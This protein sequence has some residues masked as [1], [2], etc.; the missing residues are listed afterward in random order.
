MNRTSRNTDKKIEDLKR[1]ITEEEQ[2]VNEELSNILEITESS[3]DCLT[4]LSPEA[5]KILQEQRSRVDFFSCNFISDSPNQNKKLKSS[6]SLM[7]NYT[8]DK[9]KPGQQRNPLTVTMSSKEKLVEELVVAKDVEEFLDEKNDEE[10]TLVPARQRFNPCLL[11]WL[12]E[13][14]TSEYEHMLLNR[15]CYHCHKPYYRCD[16]K[17]FGPYCV[18]VIEHRRKFF[19]VEMMNNSE[20][21][22]SIFTK[23][24]NNALK[25][26][27]FRAVTRNALMTD[28][29]YYV[30][31]CMKHNIDSLLL[32]ME[33]EQDEIINEEST[34][35][36]LR[37]INKVKKWLDDQLNHEAYDEVNWDPSGRCPDCFEERHLCH[38]KLFHGYC[39]KR[40]KSLYCSFPS[41]MCKRTAVMTYVTTYNA[42]KHFYTWRKTEKITSM[43]FDYPP[44]CM[45]DEMKDSVNEVVKMHHEW[46]ED[47][48]TE[49]V[50]D[51][52]ESKLNH[53]GVAF[54]GNF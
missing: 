25:Y 40:L 52:K 19:P 29:T 21:V 38:L 54:N 48:N 39:N 51:W 32:D 37:P 14:S 20:L 47:K 24:Y 18:A 5:Q 36:E 16:N 46:C 4:G 49:E 34:M 6:Q 23:A 10:A 35:E 50:M 30:P 17:L 26:Y 45:E 27:N 8:V 2:N 41:A 9:K 13:R 12:P 28:A 42:A 15:I 33:T 22:V 31:A 3:S 1:L 44:A 43:T 53:H 11:T 7:S